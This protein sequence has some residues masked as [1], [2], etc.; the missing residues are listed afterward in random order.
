MI[1]TIIP[2]YLFLDVREILFGVLRGYGYTQV[3]MVL[4]VLGMIVVRQIFLA[5][6]MPRFHA[7]E[8]MYICFPVG[9][10]ATVLLLLGYYLRIRKK[11]VELEEL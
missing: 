4:S 1:H 11:C 7:I 10:V 5:V 8:L 6:T 9:W 3:P 2:F